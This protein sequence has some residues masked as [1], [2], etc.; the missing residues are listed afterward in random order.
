[1]DIMDSVSRKLARIAVPCLLQ[2]PQAQPSRSRFLTRTVWVGVNVNNTIAGWPPNLKVTLQLHRGDCK[3]IEDLFTHAWSIVGALVQA[4]TH[5][6]G[7]FVF[8]FAI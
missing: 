3:H 8:F 4:D 7:R 5:Q 1:M 6:E 2:R